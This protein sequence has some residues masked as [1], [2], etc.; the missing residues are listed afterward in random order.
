MIAIF[1]FLFTLA[2]CATGPGPQTTQPPQLKDTFSVQT[3]NKIHIVKSGETLWRISRIYQID[4]EDLVSANHIKNSQTITPG[5]T[6]LI[7]ERRSNKKNLLND[8]G[9]IWPAK[10]KIISAFK[11]KSDGVFNKG[12]DIQT[13]IDQDILA[14]GDGKIGFAGTLPGYGETIIIHHEGGFSTIY[15]GFSKI[16]IA[17]NQDIKQGSVIAKAGRVPRNSISSLHFEIRRNQQPQNPFF[18]LD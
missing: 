11:E 2:G 13:Q 8:F 12:V 7:P 9:F 18:F 4:L 16:L 17:Q 6:V 1:C 10:G 3:T 14:S 15:S 5:Q